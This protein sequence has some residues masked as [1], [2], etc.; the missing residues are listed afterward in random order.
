MIRLGS[1]LHLLAGGDALDLSVIFYIEACYLRKIMYALVLDWIVGTKIYSMDMK[2]YLGN[3][4]AMERVSQ[5]FVKRSGIF[6]NGAIG[7]Q[8]GWVVHVIYPGWRETLTNALDFYQKKSG[9]P[10]MFN[11]F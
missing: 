7:A 10:L 3:T 4:C 1:I 9:T 5:G 6:L 8:D 2:G 11:A